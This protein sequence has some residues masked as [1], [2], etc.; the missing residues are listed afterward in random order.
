MNAIY[1]WIIED[2]GSYV[3]NSSAKATMEPL[4]A[5]FF[6]NKSNAQ[7]FARKYEM[8]NAVFHKLKLTAEFV[9][10]DK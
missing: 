6:T 7:T 2:Q 5:R 3:V 8:P 1:V 10:D 9:Q 4:E